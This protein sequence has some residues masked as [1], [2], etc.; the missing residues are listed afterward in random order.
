MLDLEQRQRYKTF[1][2]EAFDIL[3]NSIQSIFP[4]KDSI[5]AIICGFKVVGRILAT[6]FVKAFHKKKKK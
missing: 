4:T 5:C 6:E 3:L 2:S 1:L